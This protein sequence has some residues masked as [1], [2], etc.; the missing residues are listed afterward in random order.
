MVTE[1]ALITVSCVLFVQM[2]LSDAVQDTFRFKSRIASCPKCLSMWANLVYLLAT[3][4]GLIV[5][6][7]ASFI[8]S[9]CALWLALLYDAVATLYNYLYDS[10]TTKT[11]TAEDPVEADAAEAGG[12]DAVSEMQISDDTL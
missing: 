11:D 7:A 8:C 4:H 2:G 6:V 1:A 9:Y 10:I 5:S 12:P 3:R